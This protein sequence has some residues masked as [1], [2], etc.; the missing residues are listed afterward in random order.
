MSAILKFFAAARSLAN[1]GLSKEAIEQFAKNE[2]G[3]I[4]ELLQ[5]Q[6]NNIFKP[7]KGITSIKKDPDFD[8]TVIQMQIDEFGP[9]NPKDP[10]KNL[11]KQ[12]EGLP[13]IKKG[14]KRQLTDDEIEELDMDVG[15]LEYFDFDGTVGSANKIR[16]QRADYIA[17]MELEYKKGNLDPVAGDKSPARKRFLEK[18]LYKSLL[19]LRDVVVFHSLLSGIPSRICSIVVCKLFSNYSTKLAPSK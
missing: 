3:E 19:N 2:F 14:N 17:D 7:G 1:Q 16:K 4:N 8:D 13:S 5:R 10:L 12:T 18:N 6:I 11:K 15:G 9:Y